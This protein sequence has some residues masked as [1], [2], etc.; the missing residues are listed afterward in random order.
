MKTIMKTLV[1]VL[2]YA[3]MTTIF[4]GCD[5]NEITG[6]FMYQIG[7]SDTSTAYYTSYWASGAEATVLAEVAKV[8][9]KLD[10]G[11]NVYK[12]NGSESDCNKKIKAAVDAGMDKVESQG[13]YG[14]LFDISGVTVII[15]EIIND[16]TVYSRKFK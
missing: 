4:T 2:C 3:M 16:N 15:T 14:S 13:N 10:V 11:T 8:A 7:V 5:K 6:D 12:L 1:A 9:T